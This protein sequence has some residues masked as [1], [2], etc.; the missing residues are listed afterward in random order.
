LDFDFNPL[1]P[2][3][4]TKKNAVKG[5]V[6]IRKY[7]QM[8]LPVESLRTTQLQMQLDTKKGRDTYFTMD[9]IYEFN[10]KQLTPKFTKTV[11]YPG[12]LKSRRHM[13]TGLLSHLTYLRFK[14]EK[15]VK[16]RKWVFH[17]KYLQQ[18]LNENF[19][20]TIKRISFTP[21]KGVVLDIYVTADQV[22]SRDEETSTT[23]KEFK[24]STDEIINF[25]NVNRYLQRP[26]IQGEE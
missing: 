9:N 2:I 19:S 20:A 4:N 5:E 25:L 26:Y 22:L 1:R 11:L 13:K 3:P 8:N 16:G 15:T 23:P 24:E 10:L 18:N 14:R 21:K 12:V 17:G 6:I 7:Y